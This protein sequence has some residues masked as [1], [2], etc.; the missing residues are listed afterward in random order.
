[1]SRERRTA[2]VDLA[3][4]AAHVG[5]HDA[6]L[7]A[8]APTARSAD[9]DAAAADPG[10]FIGSLTRRV[11]HWVRA[12]MAAE[13]TA[14]GFSDLNPAHVAV[15]R[16][17]S[18]DGMSPSELATQLQITKQSV[19]ELL[20]HLERR[21]YLRREPDSHHARRRRIR[22]TDRGHDALAV[23]HA[24]AW[25]AEREAADLLGEQRLTELRH[26]L[27][28]LVTHLDAIP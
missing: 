16:T 2:A 25:R 24:A 15:F 28:D 21:G 26:T 20:G 17:P 9:A 12:R 3:S 13:V 1:M 11:H 8:T 7:T 23:A 22:L 6:A 27:T 19:N 18:P 4:P 10:P 14:A 5:A